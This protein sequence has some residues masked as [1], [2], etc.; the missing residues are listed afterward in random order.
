MSFI[1]FE[2]DENTHILS[3]L[4]VLDSQNM[5]LNLINMFVAEELSRAFCNTQLK[6]IAR[7]RAS[8][9]LRKEYFEKSDRWLHQFGL[10]QPMIVEVYLSFESICCKLTPWRML[11]NTIDIIPCNLQC[12][13]YIFSTNGYALYSLLQIKCIKNCNYCLKELWLKIA[14]FTCSRWTKWM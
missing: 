1:W 8:S 6:W 2:M 7:M 4:F 5:F 9:N 12:Y 13:F 3:W 14:C 11:Q 10:I